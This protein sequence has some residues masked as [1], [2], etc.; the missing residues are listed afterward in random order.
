MSKKIHLALE[1][2][3]L[4]TAL[5]SIIDH[6]NKEELV[7]LLAPLIGSNSTATSYFIKLMLNGKLPETLPVGTLCYVKIEALSWGT[8]KE[9]TIASKY[10]NGK[11]EVPCV[12]T[13]FRGHHEPYIYFV[14]YMQIDKNGLERKDITPVRESDITEIEE[15]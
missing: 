12:I 4:Y 13:E 14:E 10:N 3:E 9:K 1:D 6:S 15:F 11:N 2:T 7:A 5:N 8:D